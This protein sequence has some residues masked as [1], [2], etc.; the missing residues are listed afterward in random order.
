MKWAKYL[1]L[2]IMG[3]VLLGIVFRSV[4]NSQ[5]VGHTNYRFNMAVIDEEKGVS[6][7]SF[8]P[9][10]R[11]VLTIPFPKDLVIESR[12]S[13][14]YS[15][16]SLYKLGSYNGEG[17]KFARQKIQGFMRVPV[18]GYLVGQG[19]ITKLLLA[20]VI[21]R[22][23]S[24][25]SP[26]D[27][28]RLLTWYGQFRHKVVTAEELSRAS[29]IDENKYRSERFQE[30]IGTRLFDWGIGGK[31]ITVAIVNASGENGLGN[32]L[33][34]FLHNLGMDIVMVR[35]VNKSDDY[36]EKTTWQTVDKENISDLS[37]IFENLFDMGLANVEIVSEEY[38]ASVLIKVGKDAKNLF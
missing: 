6:F 17:G 27:A 28:L 7:V 4:K 30:Y 13:G 36:L 12:S 34:D 37:Y 18:P 14:E 24:S 38:R 19:G 21:G 2:S 15:I 23:E 22:T 1:L 32:D 25:L 29:V 16:A 9:V 8:D 31:E 3:I 35:S 5:L 11:S 33:A 20:T 26:I 10:E